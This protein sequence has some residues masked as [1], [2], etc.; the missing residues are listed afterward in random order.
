MRKAERN[1]FSGLWDYTEILD[2]AKALPPEI[3]TAVIPSHGYARLFVALTFSSPVLMDLVD[4]QRKG[5]GLIIDGEQSLILASRSVV[6]HGLGDILITIAGSI[7]VSGSIQI[8]GFHPLSNMVLIRYDPKLVVASIPSIKL[9]T[10]PVA[11][12]DQLT[13]LGWEGNNF[14]SVATSV[15]SIDTVIPQDGHCELPWYRPSPIEGITIDTDKV[16]ACDE[17]SVCIDDSDIVQVLCLAYREDDE[18][19]MENWTRYGVAPPRDWNKTQQHR[20]L[21]VDFRVISLDEARVIGVPDNWITRLS[22][23]NKIAPQVLQVSKPF[24]DY[25]CGL[26]ES[27]VILEVNGQLATDASSLSLANSQERLSFMIFRQGIVEGV[28]VVT[29]PAEDL[30]KTRVISWCGA[31][32]HA[33]YYA[34]YQEVRKLPSKVYISSHS[35]G[36]PSAFHNLEPTNFIVQVNNTPTPD[37]STFMEAIETGTDFRVK[38]EAVK[39]CPKGHSSL[40]GIIKHRSWRTPF[41]YHYDGV[42]F[43]GAVF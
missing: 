26:L 33:P 17:V 18:E 13:F 24:A 39:G 3:Q 43:A 31:I 23:N 42:Q 6:G 5:R 7:T 37:L 29:F 14:Y 41:H 36:S 28:E 21:P 22:P 10:G 15:T 35:L 38:L 32:I 4:Q 34:V 20:I 30:E 40:V 11:V 1:D 9:G 16:F 27:D 12:G 2:L 25:Q 8:G 19:G